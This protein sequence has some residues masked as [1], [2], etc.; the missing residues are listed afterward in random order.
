MGG[1]HEGTQGEAGSYC[2]GGVSKLGDSVVLRDGTVIEL[3]EELAKEIAARSAKGDS[4]VQIIA[5]YGLN[6]KA[7]LVWLRDNHYE[8]MQDAKREQNEGE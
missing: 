1:A 4:V 6:K 3:N 5:E 8:L 7:T 2:E